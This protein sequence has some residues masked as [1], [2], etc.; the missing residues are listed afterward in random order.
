VA[1][2]QHGGPSTP[3]RP[4]ASA[5]PPR[6]S[7]AG[8]GAPLSLPRGTR[9]GDLPRPPAPEPPRYRI[10]QADELAAL[11]AREASH[12]SHSS[13]LAGCQRAPGPLSWPGRLTQEPAAL[14]DGLDA[15]G[16]DAMAQTGR[17][18]RMMEPAAR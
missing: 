13:L 15:D 18:P 2:G 9:S 4:P 10:R 14:L 6:A 1:S 11:N 12:P 16:G 17:V 3:A 7:P 5:A 8:R